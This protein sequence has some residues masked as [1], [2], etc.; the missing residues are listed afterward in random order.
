[1]IDNGSARKYLLYAMGEIALVVLGILIALNINN[2]NI[3]SQQEIK[4]VALLETIL[5]DLS[6]DINNANEVLEFETVQDS[7]T[8]MIMKGELTKEMY[9]TTNCLYSN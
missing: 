3:Q 5:N 2:N 8:K 9:N 4:V 6:A 1:M 7:I